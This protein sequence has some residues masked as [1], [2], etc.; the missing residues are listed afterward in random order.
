MID[1]E[2]VALVVET[3]AQ[4]LV[5]QRTREIHRDVVLARINDLDR[6]PHRLGGDRG[7]HHHVGVEPAS[8]TAAEPGLMDHHVL[9]IDSDCS[10]R[11]AVERVMN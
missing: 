1:R 5:G 2:D 11:I 8:E 7:R 10:G 6:L 3:R 9:G 4:L